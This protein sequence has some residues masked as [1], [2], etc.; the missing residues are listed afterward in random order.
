MSSSAFE[1]R[2]MSNST[3]WLAVGF[4]AGIIGVVVFHQL[5]LA[6]LHAAGLT[7]G[8]AYSTKP[9]S[10]MGVPQFV[11]LAFWGGLWGILGALLFQRLTGAR[12]V[13]TF[14]VFGAIAPTLVAWF[15]VAPMKGLPMAAGFKPAAMMVGPMVN[16]AWGLGTGLVLAWFRDRGR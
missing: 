13:A 15:V 4:V 1:Q 6:A 11:S 2:P 8:M 5:A 14:V 9:T 3:A 12:L 7:P 16:A 10:P